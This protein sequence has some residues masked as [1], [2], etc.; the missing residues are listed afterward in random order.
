[1][2]T[3]VPMIHQPIVLFDGVCNFCDNSVQFIIKKDQ[4]KN[5][6][7]SS[8]QSDAGQKL[9]MKYGLPLSDFDTFI[10][11]ENNQAYKKSSAGLRVLRKLPNFSIFYYLLIWIPKFFRDFLYSLI[12]RNRYRW[13]GKKDAC[14][15]PPPDIKERFLD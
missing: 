7:F 11:I 13:F 14:M 1:M 3:F 4:K 15:I 2:L 6:L 8:L 10:L 12:A 5:F 9:L